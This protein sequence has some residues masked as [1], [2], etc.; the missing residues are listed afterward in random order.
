MEERKGFDF[1]QFI[2]D[3]RDVLLSPKDFFPQLTL[4]GGLGEPLI[5]VLIYGALVG[6]FNMIWSFMHIGGAFGGVFGGAFGVGALFTTIIGAIIGAFIMGVIFLILSSICGGNTDYEANFR[7]A[8]ALMVVYPISAFLNVLGGLSYWLSTLVGLAVNLY[9]LY[10]L[11]HGLTIALKGKEETARVVG[12]VLAGL[13]ILSMLIAGATRQAA[14]SFT[15][16]GTSRFEKKIKEF[17]KIAKEMEKSAKEDYKS[18]LEDLEAQDDDFVDDADMD[19]SMVKPL[20]FPDDAANYAKD[21]FAK[22]DL[23]VTEE[24][25]EKLIEVTKELKMLGKDQQAEQL[26]IIEIYG[27]SGVE[28]YQKEYLAS[29]MAFEGLKGLVALQKLIDASSAE[30]KVA[31]AFTLDQAI[32]SVVKQTFAAGNVTRSDVDAAFDNWNRLVELSK[33]SQRN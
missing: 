19:V 15:G 16:F 6:L 20:S 26:K 8:V 7:V 25:I 17:E 32:E 13:L 28:E 4:S 5:K 14:K 22:G 23:K 18:I 31:E 30:Q 24:K 33:L 9:A 29:I 21:W 2:N 3:S 27:Y 12:Y 11:Y 10:I 1:Q